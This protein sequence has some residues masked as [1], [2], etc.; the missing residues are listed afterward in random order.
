MQRRKAYVVYR[1]PGL[2]RRAFAG[3]HLSLTTSSVATEAVKK[4]FRVFFFAV[5]M[6]RGV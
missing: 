3:R 6:N 5:G 1:V 4:Q 2:G